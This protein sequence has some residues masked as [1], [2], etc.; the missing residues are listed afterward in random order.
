MDRL[1]LLVF[2]ISCLVGTTSIILQA[3][4]FYDS[5]VPLDELI[6][7]NLPIENISVI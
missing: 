7:N 6:R 1:F 3:P 4:S 2:I 5:K